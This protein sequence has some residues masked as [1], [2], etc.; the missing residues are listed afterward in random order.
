MRKKKRA[1]IFLCS[2]AAFLV[3][4]GC[5]AALYFIDMPKQAVE[6]P[7]SGINYY[8]ANKLI[9]IGAASERY[10]FLLVF[11]CKEENCRIVCAS[12]DQIDA[13][14]TKEAFLKIF[15]I[16]PDITA[17]FKSDRLI[18]EITKIGGFFI[19]GEYYTGVET[20]N[21]LNETAVNKEDYDRLC[22]ITGEF[23]KKEIEHKSGYLFECSD[24]SRPWFEDNRDTLLAAIKNKSYDYIL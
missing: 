15:G 24:A 8:G 18:A 23:I 12:K 4:A 17:D 13:E 6:K 9:R 5:V 7:E 11:N 1:V 14:N 22:A 20:V 2:A 3:F 19:D 16:T 10:I 21:A